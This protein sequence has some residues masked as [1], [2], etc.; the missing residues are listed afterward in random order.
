MTA[1]GNRPGQPRRAARLVALVGGAVA[2]ALALGE[3]EQ[4]PDVVE[5]R[6]GHHGVRRAGGPGQ[7]GRLLGVGELEDLLVVEL[8]AVARRGG[9][10]PRRSTGPSRDRPALEVADERHG[11]LDRRA[12]PASARSTPP[13]GR[14]R[15]ARCT[16]G[17]APA[18]GVGPR[19]GPLRCGRARVEPQRLAGPH[20]HRRPVER[21]PRRRGGCSRCRPSG[22]SSWC[23]P[24]T[25]SR[26][27]LSTQRVVD[28]DHARHVRL[29]EAV[30]GRV[31][32]R[33]V[34]GAAGQLVVDLLLVEHGRLAEQRR[35]G[36]QHR[37]RREQ[38]RG[39]PRGTA[40]SSRCDRAAARR[41]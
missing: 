33:R 39:A 17:T 7:R 36:R 35:R 37:P 29:D 16:W 13:A 24:D 14:P 40:R 31:L 2:G 34:A 38:R 1:G 10:A 22:S 4:V 28:G 3:L 32:V 21:R 26:Q 18:A 25:T 6:G 41:R 30:R 23:R 5:Q 27:P 8:G 9:R 19:L 20:L 15:R 11:R 12:R